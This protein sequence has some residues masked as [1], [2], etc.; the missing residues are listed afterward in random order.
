MFK[1][2]FLILALFV[3]LPN[4]V[5]AVP[6]GPSAKLYV[7]NDYSY[8][9]S[10]SHQ[11]RVSSTTTNLE[12][13]KLIEILNSLIDQLNVILGQKCAEI[14]HPTGVTVDLK[15]YPPDDEYLLK[16]TGDVRITV[17][18]EFS[19]KAILFYGDG[20][21]EF[22]T[23]ISKNTF[24]KT[25]SHSYN[26]G[27]TAQEYD[28]TVT[29]TD[30]IKGGEV[31]DPDI[32]KNPFNAENQIIS[33]KHISIRR[34]DTQASFA[35]LN[36]Q[37]F[38]TDKPNLSGSASR[39][40]SYLHMIITDRNNAEVYKNSH[41]SISSTAKWSVQLSN[42]LKNGDYTVKL[43]SPLN[44]V[45]IQE[46]MTINKPTYDT[47]TSFSKEGL[48]K[49]ESFSGDAF[50]TTN[51]ISYQDALNNCKLN[52]SSNPTRPYL[53]IWNGHEIYSQTGNN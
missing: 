1:R 26:A 33:R 9:C 27:N 18:S 23:R 41:I 4:L 38:D 8:D 36:R 47:S 5:F 35:T 15:V 49:Y 2:Y 10:I 6:G 28:I 13:K 37:N 22:I 31:T 30:S 7:E 44:A 20:T 46:R 51:G 34:L 39:D 16:I 32:M 14:K 12:L 50:G 43:F 29:L 42:P 40:L 53:C 25:L 19:G 48:G 52:A 45:L 11:P 17:P 24:E 21:S 3:A